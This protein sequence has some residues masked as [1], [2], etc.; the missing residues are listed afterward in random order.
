MG[1]LIREAVECFGDKIF[2]GPIK[3]FWHGINQEM[4]FHGTVSQI[5]GALSTSSQREVAINFSQYTGLVLEL[6]NGAEH[7]SANYFSCAWLS[8]FSNESE[9]LFIGGL[10]PLQFIRI[11]HVQYNLDYV[12]YLKCL[13]IIN[14]MFD[15]R[16]Y[17][18]HG[19]KEKYFN[20]LIAKTVKKMIHHY[21]SRFDSTGMYTAFK[22]MPEYIDR[23]L[24]HC[25]EYRKYICIDW[26]YMHIQFDQ[27]KNKGY[28]I[29]K[30]YIC[31]DDYEW[32][33]IDLLCELFYNL[34]YIEL[35][36]GY[37]N[38]IKLCHNTMDDIFEFF[39]S[40]SNCCVNV[41]KIQ[42]NNETSEMKP[43]IAIN[44]YKKQF[45]IIGFKLDLLYGE[46]LTIK[47]NIFKKREYEIQRELSPKILVKRI[48]SNDIIENYIPTENINDE[49]ITTVDDT[50][51]ENENDKQKIDGGK[52]K[53]TRDKLKD[54]CIIS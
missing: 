21:L 6:M 42:C 13:N 53:E 31:K 43:E 8:D 25:F 48:K 12:V 7:H 18:D 51:K 38:K 47:R 49:I 1:K 28:E 22:D 26:E 3:A 29:A 27:W 15:G 34:N 41:I 32:I 17:E 9:Y 10:Q 45:D 39:S 11:I 33:N 2:G 37:T 50:N 5:K 16:L 44:H 35:K 54:H 36:N 23:L 20:K 19:N 24:C 40:N 4:L 46:W 30:K 52:Y 14:K